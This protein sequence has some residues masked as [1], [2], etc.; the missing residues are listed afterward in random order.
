MYA[1][2]CV[3]SST[4]CVQLAFAMLK[5]VEVANFRAFDHLR[6]DQLSLVNL[7]SGRNNTGKTAL[8]EAIFVQ[9]SPLQP[10][11]ATSFSHRGEGRSGFPSL[12]IGLRYYDEWQTLFFDRRVND[13][14]QLSSRS[15]DGHQ[16]TL[17]IM[18]REAEV[19]LIEPPRNKAEGID[20]G[21]ASTD[22]PSF[23]LVYVFES[24]DGTRAE[25][26]AT[27][28]LLPG[29]M[30]RERLQITRGWNKR[31]SL[32][33]ATL[34]GTDRQPRAQIAENYSGL[35]DDKR[36]SPIEQILRELDPRLKS[37]EI[38]VEARR[39]ELAADLGLSQLMPLRMMGEGVT[40]IVEILVAIFGA[41]DGFVL[42]DEIENG[43]HYSVLP[44]VWDAIIRAARQA[45]AQLFATTHSFECI[46]AAHEAAVERPSDLRLHRLDRTDSGVSATTYDQETIDASLAM[47]VETR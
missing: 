31:P 19:Q 12:P 29:T 11:L 38:R 1:R 8:L 22:E 32:P 21:V 45:N 41:R 18:L 47:G 33:K 30:P 7:I 6:V 24:T 5:S 35:R 28:S 16:Q 39:P 43:L 10:Q 40:R 9:L 15:I 3:Q 27:P 2:R 46:R 4:L 17:G 13:P 34:L 37:L 14:I 42:V 26:V 25:T 44:R 36:H 20:Q 23:E